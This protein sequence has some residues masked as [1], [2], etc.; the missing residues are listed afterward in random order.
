MRDGADIRLVISG[1]SPDISGQ[2]SGIRQYILS[3][4]PESRRSTLTGYPE[5]VISIS[6]KLDPGVFIGSG[7]GFQNMVESGF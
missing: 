4:I 3:N 5:Y 7:S 6:S 2:K 1:I